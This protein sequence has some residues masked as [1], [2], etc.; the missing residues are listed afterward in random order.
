M[1]V[2]CMNHM[3]ISMTKDNNTIHAQM[4]IVPSSGMSKEERRQ[5]VLDTNHVLVLGGFPG[6]ML[7]RKDEPVVVVKIDDFE[8]TWPGMF[9]V[10]VLRNLENGE[11][12]TFK[13]NDGLVFLE[14][15]QSISPSDDLTSFREAIQF[16]AI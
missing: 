11:C 8:H 12:I 16:A 1:F 10:R 3:E 13:T 7:I 4:Y 15:D 6:D 9:P 2:E 14:V 5:H